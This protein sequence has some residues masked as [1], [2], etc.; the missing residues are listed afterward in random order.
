MNVCENVIAK[1]WNSSSVDCIDGIGTIIILNT[2]THT[3]TLTERKKPF[4]SSFFYSLMKRVSL[5]GRLWVLFCF[6]ILTY[7][8]QESRALAFLWRM[9]FIRNFDEEHHF[10]NLY[11]V[12]LFFAQFSFATKLFFMHRHIY[13]VL[14]K[15]ALYIHKM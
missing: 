3:H 7:A 1:N 15:R 13:T 12:W 14:A 10:I 5:W 4:A 2:E 9:Y 6:H 8:M 11:F